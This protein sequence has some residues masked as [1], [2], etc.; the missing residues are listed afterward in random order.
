VRAHRHG[1][2]GGGGVWLVL[3]AGWSWVV[4]RVAGCPWR[5]WRAMWRGKGG[6]AWRAMLARWACVLLVGPVTALATEYHVF[7]TDKVGRTCSS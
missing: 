5:G 4:A 6:L 1:A 2:C 7:G 3:A